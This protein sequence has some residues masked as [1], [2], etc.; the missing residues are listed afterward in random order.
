M[1]ACRQATAGAGVIRAEVI[2]GAK[3]TRF[4]KWGRKYLLRKPGGYSFPRF[5]PSGSCTFSDLKTG[6]PED[7]HIEIAAGS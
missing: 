3:S 2:D 5:P 6:N 1:S 7:S 4:T